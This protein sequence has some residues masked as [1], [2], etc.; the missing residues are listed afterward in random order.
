[1]PFYTIKNYFRHFG[2]VK[3]VADN[4]HLPVSPAAAC[5]S[6]GIST[7]CIWEPSF[8]LSTASS[9]VCA[10]SQTST[11]DAYIGL[12][13]NVVMLYVAVCALLS[14]YL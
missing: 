3:W 14:A 7:W 5:S 12:F 11:N 6:V 1:M 13:K 8:N 4:L 9:S 2:G 10:P